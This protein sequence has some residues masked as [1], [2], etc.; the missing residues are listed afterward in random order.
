MDKRNGETTNEYFAL[1]FLGF[2]LV[3]KCKRIDRLFYCTLCLVILI[4]FTV[5]F[6]LIITFFHLPPIKIDQSLVE[7]RFVLDQ[8]KGGEI[9]PS[10]NLLCSAYLLNLEIQ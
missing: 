2:K 7:Y 6:F 9:F 8:L 4:L 3:V 1:R 5:K 10:F